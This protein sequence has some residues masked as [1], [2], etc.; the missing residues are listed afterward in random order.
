M[1]VVMKNK[2]LNLPLLTMI[3]VSTVTDLYKY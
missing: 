2:K 3:K 1:K